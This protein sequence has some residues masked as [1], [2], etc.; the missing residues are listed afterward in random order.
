[1][2]KKIKIILLIVLLATLSFVG[3][4]IYLSGP[5][6]SKGTEKSFVI[7]SGQ[8]TREIATKL[9]DEGLIKSSNYFLVYA[10][11]RHGYI[12]AGVYQLSPS[13]STPEICK[14]LMGN[15]ASE[16]YVTIPE[17]WRVTQIDAQLGAKG[18]INAG[19]FTRIAASDEGN[20]F[21]DTYRFLPKTD[22]KIIRETMLENFEKKT[23]AMNV[24]QQTIIIASIVEREAKFDEDR[25]KIAAV[26]LNRLKVGMKL[27][28]DPT[29]Q[30]AKG[31][32]DPITLSDYQDV[33]SSYNT[34]L[35]EGLPPGAICNPGLKSIEAVLNPASVD[36]YYFFHKKDGRAVYSKT[37]EEHE[38]NLRAYRNGL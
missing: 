33:F 35:H 26:Y 32:W 10:K 29:V 17:G 19:E 11:L 24:T 25:P 36:Y 1:M 4:F 6:D 9:E 28:A 7:K 20:L 31:S 12:Q 18:I 37:L 13:Q 15:S 16:Y 27:E 2:S 8:T 5:K 38:S 30:Y 34:Y 23:A 21:P 22:P 14:E 3:L